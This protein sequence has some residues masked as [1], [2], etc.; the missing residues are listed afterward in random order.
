MTVDGDYVLSTLRLRLKT[1][2]A[3]MP[4][5]IRNRVKGGC[6]FFTVNLANRKSNLLTENM[7]ALREAVRITKNKHPFHID[8]WVVLPEH[9]HCIW[10]LPADDN[11]Y[12]SR[13]RMI[14][15][16]FS[17]SIPKTESRTQTQ[18]KRGERGIW[19]RRYWEHTI[20]DEVDYAKH[21]DYLHFN[22]VKHGLVERVADW[23][24]SSFHRLVQAGI[25]ATDWGLATDLK[26]SV[27]EAHGG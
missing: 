24:F 13:W 22:P 14:K 27:G 11:D 20:R 17:K 6:Y 2:N 18:L 26:M 19:Q 8:G 9:M 10:T 5:Y 12:P 15:K 7:D 4:N 21:M 23:H 1:R 3:S 16:T 25:Y